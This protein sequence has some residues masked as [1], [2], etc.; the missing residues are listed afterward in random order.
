MRRRIIASIVAAS[1]ALGII[2]WL[3]E[4]FW[5]YPEPNQVDESPASGNG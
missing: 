3:F 1:M 5:Q 4:T 2:S